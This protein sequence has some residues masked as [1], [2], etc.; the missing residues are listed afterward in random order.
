MPTF[1]QIGSAVVVGAGGQATISFTGIPNTFTDLCLK[2]SART[3]RT[4]D[5]SDVDLTVNGQTAATGIVV[6]VIEG[7][8][9]GSYAPASASVAIASAANNTANSFGSSEI[10]ITNYA[11]TGIKSMSA[12]AVGENNGTNTA[13]TLSGATV[14]NGAAITSITLTPQAGAS[15]VQYS[16]AYLY[17]VSNA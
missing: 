2:L 15:F 1:N 6:Y 3:G 12:D 17:G 11:S 14:T 16:T 10:Y 8:T 13:L 9:K 5:Y 7:T 4:A